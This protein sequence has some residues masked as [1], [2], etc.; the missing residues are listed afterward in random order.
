MDLKKIDAI[1][2][3][4]PQICKLN[5][6]CQ[7][8]ITDLN[9]VGGIQAMLKELDKGGLIHRDLLTVSG[10]VADR[11]CRRARMR[12]A[13]LSAGWTTPFRKDGGIADSLRQ[14]GRGGRGGQAGGR[15]APK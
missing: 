14:S 2:K 8:F 12:T 10:T 6:A 4:T 1:G 15:G 3:T 5:P 13:R 7:V 9:E 11:I